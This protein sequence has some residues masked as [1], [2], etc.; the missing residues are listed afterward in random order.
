MKSQVIVKNIEN[1]SLKQIA[2]S[3]Q[4][5]RWQVQSD[6]SYVVTA[7][8]ETI[9]LI[10]DG[11]DLIIKGISEKSYENKWYHYFDLSRNYKKVIKDLK[12]RD[13]YLD[14]AIEYGK[15]IRILNQDLWEIIITF[16]ISSNNNIPRIKNS[17]EMLSR[18]YG[19]YIK[20]INGEDYYS[21][22]NAGTLSR[23]KIEDL[24]ACG[25]GYRDKYILKTSQMIADGRVNLNEIKNMSLING[26]TELK[27]LMGVGNKVADCILLFACEEPAA[28]PVDTWV[29]KVLADYYD[30]HNKKSAEINAFVNDHFGKFAGIAQQYLFYYIRKTGHLK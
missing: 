23:A 12:G 17:I 8:N 3:G 10:E 27:K 24:R 2:E 6:E 19:S 7:M 18:K 30:F 20:T 22:P 14:A 13:Q 21:F 5:F 28:F 4:S 11:N 29:K 25:L 15:G 9:Q 16:I 1:F 26:K